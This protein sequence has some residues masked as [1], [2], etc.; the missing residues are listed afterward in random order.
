MIYQPEEN[1]DYVAQFNIDTLEKRAYKAGESILAKR[2]QAEREAETAQ[3][4]KAR[5]INYGR[6]Y[7]LLKIEG[8]HAVL[9]GNI[10]YR[11]WRLP[12]GS[13]LVYDGK[14]K[15][16]NPNR[17]IISFERRD[18]LLRPLYTV[19]SIDVGATGQQFAKMR[20]GGKS[21]EVYYHRVGEKLYGGGIIQSID[22]K[23][24]NVMWDGQRI[25]LPVMN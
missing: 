18:Y 11:V 5:G 19:E 4:K 14:L 13:E 25:S 7:S 8:Q 3:Y 2:H 9:I 24:V 17:A 15:S 12:V 1:F 6:L 23:N 22:A 10:T 21:G 20:W 16:V